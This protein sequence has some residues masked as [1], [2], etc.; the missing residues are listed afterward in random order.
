MKKIVFIGAGG[1]SKSVADALAPGYELI[2]Y[3]DEFKEGSFC[4]RPIFGHCIEDVPDFRSCAYFVT[5]GD[6]GFRRMWFE[7]VKALGLETI[8]I[9]DPTACISKDVRM[10]TG[11]FVGK[12]AIINADAVLGD[13]NIINTR[14]LVE[15][16]CHVGDHIHLST[17]AMINGDVTVCDGAFLGTSSTCIGQ[18]KIGENTV[19]GAGGVVIGD[20]PANVTAVGV[21]V[22]II[23]RRSE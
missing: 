19:V 21:P 18:L 13:D 12:Y 9:I 7:R 6:N 17:G 8:N 14:A 23:K 3:V 4:S 2:G 1:H 11:N 10:G 20:L 22:K 15:H 5:I 16:E